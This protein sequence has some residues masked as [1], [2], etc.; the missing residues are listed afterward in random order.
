MVESLE[1]QVAE[2]N[3]PIVELRNEGKQEHEKILKILN[4]IDKKTE[5]G[6]FEKYIQPFL[7]SLINIAGFLIMN[8]KL[9][10]IKELSPVLKD[11]DRIFKQLKPEE[12]KELSNLLSETVHKNVHYRKD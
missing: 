8:N 1:K 10:D 5:K 12:Q 4:D 7:P 11:I 2:K 9:N 6:I 3:K